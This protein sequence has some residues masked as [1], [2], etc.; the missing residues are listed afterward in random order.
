MARRERRGGAAGCGERRDPLP[1]DLHH[2]GRSRWLAALHGVL[3][4]R[5][6]RRCGRLQQSRVRVHVPIAFVTAPAAGGELVDGHRHVASD[7][8]NDLA[9]RDRP[10]GGRLRRSQR[11]RDRGSDEDVRLP[12][13]EQGHAGVSLAR[14]RLVDGHVDRL[15]GVRRLLH[16]CVVVLYAEAE[17]EWAPH[18]LAQGR[19]CRPGVPRGDS[20]DGRLRDCS[21]ACA[22][23]LLALALLASGRKAQQALS[24]HRHLHRLRRRLLPEELEVCHPPGLP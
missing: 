24:G 22:S 8:L 18:A 4:P 7:P 6:D 3:P 10:H 1:G 2:L 19:R 11:H 17:G 5:G 20:G 23:S 16:G 15:V 13:P 12:S 9:R 14:L 21:L